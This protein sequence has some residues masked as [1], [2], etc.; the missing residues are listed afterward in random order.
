MI[1]FTARKTIFEKVLEFEV[2]LSEKGFENNK[3]I[4]LENGFSLLNIKKI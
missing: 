4:L 3:L 1:S 2:K